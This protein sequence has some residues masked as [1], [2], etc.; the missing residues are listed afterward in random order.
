MAGR[1]TVWAKTMKYL[2]WSGEKD[3]QVLK[4]AKTGMFYADIADIMGCRKDAIQ[5]RLNRLGYRRPVRRRQNPFGYRDD[6]WPAQTWFG[7]EH[8]RPDFAAAAERVR[9]VVNEVLK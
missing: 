3:S 4:L 9:A 2:S 5:Q 8:T 6:K 7:P 1:C